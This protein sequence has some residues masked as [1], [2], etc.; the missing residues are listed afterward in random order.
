[1]LNLAYVNNE[2]HMKEKPMEGL[3][4]SHTGRWMVIS[5]DT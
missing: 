1:M 3:N 2:T 5:W 4:N